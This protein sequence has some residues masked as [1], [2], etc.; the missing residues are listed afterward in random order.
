MPGGQ[1]GHPVA[2]EYKQGDLDLQVRGVSN[3]MWS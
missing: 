1:L 3:E 2:G